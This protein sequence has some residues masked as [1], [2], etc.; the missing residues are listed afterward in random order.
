MKSGGVRI[1]VTLFENWGTSKQKCTSIRKITLCDMTEIHLIFEG[2]L[3][4]VST[5]VYEVHQNTYLMF[6]R[7]RSVLGEISFSLLHSTLPVGSESHVIL[8]SM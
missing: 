2:C 8:I 6:L 4:F 3:S 1:K 5:F 7:L